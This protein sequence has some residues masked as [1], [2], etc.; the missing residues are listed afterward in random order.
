V[1]VEAGTSSSSSNNNNNSRRYDFLLKVVGVS[2][3]YWILVRGSKRKFKSRH[4]TGS[5]E[6]AL[7]YA[8]YRRAETGFLGILSMI[9]ILKN[10]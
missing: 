10:S 1:T 4:A 5:K 8:V 6:T 7:L 2:R 9:G 3:Q